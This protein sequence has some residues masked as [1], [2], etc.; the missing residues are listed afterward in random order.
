MIGAGPTPAAAV[1]SAAAE[2]TPAPA[3]GDRRVLVAEDHPVNRLVARRV[4]EKL[5]CQVDLAANGIEALSKL[6][7]GSYDIVFMDCQMPE[8]D[9]YE[10]TAAIRRHHPGEPRLPIAAMTAEVMKGDR[11]KCL[12]A[13]MDD[14]VSKPIDVVL[15]GEVV[16]R[17]APRQTGTGKTAKR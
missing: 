17:W 7:A 8:M 1:P 14:Y 10:A 6:A 9:G 4:L 2:P 11:E 15:L 5:G 12:E 13:G 16:E 3:G